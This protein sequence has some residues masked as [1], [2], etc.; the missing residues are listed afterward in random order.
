MFFDCV[1]YDNKVFAV[2]NTQTYKELKSDPTVRIERCCSKV[3]SKLSAL[4]KS[5]MLRPSATVCPKFYGLPKIHQPCAPLGPIVASQV[6][7][8]II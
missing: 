3:C 1:Q 6:L 2:L 7:Q 5:D 8:L 4:K